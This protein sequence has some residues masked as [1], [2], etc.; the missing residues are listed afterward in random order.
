MLNQQKS[1]DVVIDWFKQIKNK[2]LFKFETSDIKELYPSIK[3]CLLK[4][5]INFAEQHTEISE[6]DKSM[7]FYPRKS[8]L[9][10][11]QHV[12]I[13]KER[14]LFDA[15]MGEFDGAEVWEAVGNFLFYQLSKNCN[16]KIL[17]YTGTMDWQ[18]LK[19]LVAPKQK[20]LKK[21]YKSYL[22]ITT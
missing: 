1:T 9:F 22:K 10:N 13:K 12:W 2:N 8:L 7:I 19:T 21:I 18:Y 11:G 6:K 15:T 3:E 16:K 17:V 5:A 14:G 20:K 4:N